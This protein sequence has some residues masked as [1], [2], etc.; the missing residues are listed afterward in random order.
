MLAAL[1]SPAL[2]A[3]GAAASRIA[4]RAAAALR[5][6][7]IYVDPGAQYKPDPAEVRELRERIASSH[8]GPMFIAVLPAHAAEELG[9]D[10]AAVARLLRRRLN[11]P[12]TYA[13]VVGATFRGTSSSLPAG[14]APRF[15][16]EAFDAHQEEGVGQTLLDFVNRVGDARTGRS[17]GGGSGGVVG[18]VLGGLAAVLAALLGVA[19]FRWWRNTEGLRQ[20]RRA[21]RDD[22]A[23]LAEDLRALDLEAEPYAGVLARYARAE[24]LL[25]R[26]RSPEDLEPVSAQLERARYELTRAGALVDG[27]EPPERR[28]PCFFDP[29]HGPSTREIEWSADGAPPRVVGACEADARRIEQGV[30]PD[31]RHVLVGGRP[32]P[33]W[34]AP[35][36]FGPWLAGYYATESGASGTASRASGTGQPR[37]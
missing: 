17:P 29:R 13:V 37:P 2:G 21:A 33:Y 18:A 35:A 22:L 23:S 19:A 34:A 25:D 3:Q 6:D 8:A 5:N 31:T 7:P 32:V 14:A 36:A 9:G 1:L 28:P 15:A 16:A 30:E 24:H 26:A 4:D 12:G 10:P 27:R 20:V 11:R